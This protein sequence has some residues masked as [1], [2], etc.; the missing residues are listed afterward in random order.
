[1]DENDVPDEKAREFADKVF[2][3][4]MYAE[5]K[6]KAKQ[7][8]GAKA[9]K[10]DPSGLVVDAVLRAL[11]KRDTLRDDACLRAWLT[12][13]V[14]REVLAKLRLAEIRTRAL[15]AAD[16]LPTRKSADAAQDEE[17]AYMLALLERL[18]ED[19]QTVICLCKLEEMPYAETAALLNIS[20]PAVRKRLSRAMGR[21]KKIARTS[22]REG[23][24]RS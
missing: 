7:V 11:K 14:V 8:A 21:L 20:E 1:M 19:D 3:T 2:K 5:L 6:A 24:S 23:D 17:K 15:S 18:S 22:L 4:S 9:A 16:D 12:K 13:I 10:M